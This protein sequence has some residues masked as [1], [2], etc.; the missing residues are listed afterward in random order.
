MLCCCKYGQPIVSFS[1]ICIVPAMM[2]HLTDNII[3]YRMNERWYCVHGSW[4]DVYIDENEHVYMYCNKSPSVRKKRYI[5]VS[6][7]RLL[8]L[9]LWLLSQ[10]IM[11]I[12]RYINWTLF[13][14]SQCILIS[15]F[16]YCRYTNCINLRLSSAFRFR[17]PRLMLFNE[18]HTN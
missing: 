15:V 5:S 17:Y 6:L 7:S 16:W 9:L 11:T 3:L 2:C 14:G 12:R 13:C 8:L 1:P 4:W 18:R 10:K